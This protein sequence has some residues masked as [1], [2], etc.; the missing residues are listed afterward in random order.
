MTDSLKGKVAIVTGAT[1][2]I[3]YGIAESLLREGVKVF[4][5]ARNK[6]RVREAVGDLSRSG[7]V[8]GETCDVRSEDQVR[9]M[10]EECERVFGGIDILINNAGMGIFG[11]TVEE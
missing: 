2:G 1:K 10:V 9:M 5:T 11:K 4:I 7:Q 6:S 3:G 8:N